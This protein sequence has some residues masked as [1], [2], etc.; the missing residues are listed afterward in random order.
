MRQMRVTIVLVTAVLVAC[1]S[2]AGKQH[3]S[4]SAATRSQHPSAPTSPGRSSTEL[5][6]S[7]RC[8][9]T[10]MWQSAARARLAAGVGARN[11]LG[12]GPVYPG[13]YTQQRRWPSRNPVEMHLGLRSAISTGA[14]AT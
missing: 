1:S 11:L 8:P 7:E 6:Q 14:T 5:P 9:I 4:V 2:T 13:V 3:R 10:R 12:P